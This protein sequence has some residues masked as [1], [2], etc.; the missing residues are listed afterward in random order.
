MPS[1]WTTVKSYPADDPVRIPL[2]KTGSY[3]PHCDFI[4]ENIPEAS[5]KHWYYNKYYLG[6]GHAQTM[7]ASGT[8]TH[9]YPV[10][11]GRRY[12]RQPDGGQFSV[13]YALSFV[14]AEP[15]DWQEDV[16]YLSDPE[17]PRLPNRT[18]V[19]RP[20]EVRVLDDPSSTKPLFI[21]LHGLTGG[22]HEN[23]LRAAV[24]EIDREA[25]G[26]VEVAV[27]TARGCNRSKITTPQLFNAGWTDDLRL[28]VNHVVSTQPN[29]PIFLAGYSLG[30]A[31]LA[32]YL[33]QE[34]RGVSKNI[35]A[36]I[37]LSAPMDLL[38]CHQTIC[39]TLIGRKVYQPQMA[40]NL[41][42]LVKN[43]R[44]VLETSERFRTQFAKVK[45][46]LTVVSQFD[47]LFTAPLFGFSCA[48]EYYRQASPTLV[49]QDISVPTLF[50]TAEDD[51]ICGD[52]GVPYAEA[53][54]NPFTHI[55]STTYGGHLGW[56]QQDGQRW[57]TLV[58][59]KY[60]RAFLEKTDIKAAVPMPP[61][62]EMWFQ[63][64]RYGTK[65]PSLD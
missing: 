25:P 24:C 38:I 3:T 33:G 4:A 23:Y 57:F 8:Y 40:Q 63:N 45:G 41:L 18:R 22:S 9:E 26:A 11:Y 21:H 13:D 15:E 49:L 59:A 30:G 56:F 65:P 52:V 19:L 51:P 36:A 12:F 14:N 50:L 17:T 44:K 62:R 28:L 32:N 53:S 64:H 10:W 6:N 2:A 37:V 60:T 42:R 43:N 16:K 20:E 47:D 54:K 31:I 61:K 58:M 27:V 55:L 5:P 46:P 35:K 1:P 7:L 29:R 48:M 34:G 39:S